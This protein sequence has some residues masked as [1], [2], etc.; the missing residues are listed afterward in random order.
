MDVRRLIAALM[1]LGLLVSCS[2]DGPGSGPQE[3]TGSATVSPTPTG[4]E[5]T[6][7]ANATDA[8]RGWFRALN[9]AFDSGDA[10]QLKVISAPACVTCQ[11]FITAIERTASAGGS[12]DAPDW[13][14]TRMKSLASAK[15]GALFLV[16][17]HEPAGSTIRKADDKP[18]PFPAIDDRFQVYLRHREGLWIV[19][20]VGMLS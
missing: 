5:A 1:L 17:V 9:D 4:S 14:I 10:T 7:N 15:D 16:N 20:T 18:T 8:V 6:H 2:D 3:P 12:V 11:G 13:V 19:T